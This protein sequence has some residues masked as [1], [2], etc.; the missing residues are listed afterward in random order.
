MTIL[1]EWQQNYTHCRYCGRA[2]KY[3]QYEAD[4]GIQHVYCS[5]KCGEN[6]LKE[7]NPDQYRKTQQAAKMHIGA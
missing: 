2:I 1:T 7:H 6:W 4:D 5:A 3:T